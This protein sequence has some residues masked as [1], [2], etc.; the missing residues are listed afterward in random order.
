MALQH[1][2]WQMTSGVDLV[3][4]VGGRGMVGAGASWRS[5]VTKFIY[6]RCHNFENG[7]QNNAASGASRNVFGFLPQI[8]TF[9]RYISRK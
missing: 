4:K 6:Q 2:I 7:V 1:L 9:L 8:V 5:A 3:R